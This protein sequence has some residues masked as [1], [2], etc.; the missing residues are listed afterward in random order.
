MLRPI[1]LRVGPH[2]LHD[3]PAIEVVFADGHTTFIALDVHAASAVVDR[4]REVIDGRVCA[5]PPSRRVL[6]IP[7]AGNDASYAE[8]EPPSGAMP[9]ADLELDRRTQGPLP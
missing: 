1:A 3:G 7:L 6:E 8:T 5:R 9:I 4:L 2:P